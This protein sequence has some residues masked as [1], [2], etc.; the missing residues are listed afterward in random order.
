[1]NRLNR[2]LAVF[3]FT[4]FALMVFSWMAAAAEPASAIEQTF[5]KAKKD[6][7]D[8]NINSASEQIKKGAAYM[9]EKAAKASTKGKGE[10]EES[11]RE[12]DKLAD[13]VKKGTVKSVKRIEGAFARAYHALALE[14]QIESTESWAKRERERAG[15]ALDAANKN[16]E[17]G[18]AWAGQKAEESTKKVMRK[19][20]EIALKLKRKGRLIT[21]EVGKGIQDAGKEIEKF[22]KKI[23]P[24]EDT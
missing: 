13:D 24:R 20:E 5:Q 6:Y 1:M 23:S 4:L 11:A 17:R 8:K 16:L 9:K 7:L 18:I 22:G 3:V 14:S 12:L 21:E 19:S 10:L 2:V 15:E